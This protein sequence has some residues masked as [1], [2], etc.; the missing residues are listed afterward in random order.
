MQATAICLANRDQGQ[1]YVEAAEKAVTTARLAGDVELVARALF[2]HAR[3]GVEAGNEALVCASLS[4][5]DRLLT[6]PAGAQLPILHYAQGVCHFFF[7]NI[8]AA[9]RSLERAKDLLA[10]G[11]SVIELSY[12]YNGYGNCKQYL[13]EFT[14]ARE[15]Y[16]AGL[17]VAKRI[18]DDS[19]ASIIC[20]NLCTLLVT[21]GDYQAAVQFGLQSVRFGSRAFNQPSLWIAFTCLAE[22][23]ILAGNRTAAMESLERA[24]ELVNSSVNWSASV[25]FAC[26]AAGIALVM[27]EL[28]RALSL[29]GAA[30]ESAYGKELIVPNAGL[31]EK[32]K[33]FRAAHMSGPTAALAGVEP[34]KAKF[35][36]C[37]PFYYLDVLSAAAWIEKQAFGVYT[38][39]TARELEAFKT[40]AL[41]GWRAWETAAGFL[42]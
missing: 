30:E 11:H 40:P 9:S 16:F 25:Q 8:G 41:V 27:G 7:S 20:A 1:N 22:A 14:A 19:R 5:I 13:C 26:Q 42:S 28:E 2:E 35:R 38:T 21:M 23:Y 39:A 17:E 4:E 34:A 37:Q 29:I 18:G 3:S 33:L 24:R 10:A 36:G 32:L 15:A 6:D 12:V 31:F